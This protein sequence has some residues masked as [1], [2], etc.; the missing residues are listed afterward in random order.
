M[1]VPFTNVLL[2]LFLQKFLGKTHAQK[3]VLLAR[4][5]TVH[6]EQLKSDVVKNG[7]AKSKYMLIVLILK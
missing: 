6:Q 5:V 3:S 4:E 1:L 2:F 7:S